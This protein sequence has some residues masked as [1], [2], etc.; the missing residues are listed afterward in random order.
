MEKL[1]LI[2]NVTQHIPEDTLS[3]AQKIFEPD[4]WKIL[5]HYK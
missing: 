3:N 4:H 1:I 2:I 5:V